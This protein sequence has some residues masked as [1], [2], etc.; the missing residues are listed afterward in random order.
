MTKEKDINIGSFKPKRKFISFINST[1]AGTNVRINREIAYIDGVKLSGM[2]EGSKFKITI[3]DEGTINFE[4]VDSNLTNTSMI[5]RLIGDIDNYDVK[6]Y[7]ERFVVEDLEFKDENGTKC[8]LEVE[9]QRPIDKLKSMSKT[10]P[11]SNGLDMLDK[12]FSTIKNNRNSNK[13]EDKVVEDKVVEDVV[14]EN[15]KPISKS[16]I[17]ETFN[18][19][20]D[21]KIKELKSRI[22]TIEKEKLKIESDIKVSESRIEQLSKELS[23]LET[24]LE[25]MSP[26]IEPNGYVFYV[27]HLKDSKVEIDESSKSMVDK[28]AVIMG[29]KKDVLV[30]HLSEGYYEIKVAD[31][32]K[33]DE[34]LTN[35]EVSNLIYKLDSKLVNNIDHFE[36][37]GDLNWHQII[38]KM[39]R[40]G[41]L[42][43]PEFDKISGSISYESEFGGGSPT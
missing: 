33:L 15:I 7:A 9:H 3:C 17:E 26:I 16:F 21:D 8:Y 14:L 34:S 24:R 40:L 27:S 23:T 25:T 11:T 19:M 18:K 32:N 2:L 36:Y 6:G 42:Q 39:I 29:L 13:E 10:S 20:N 38:D 35:E 4:E 12:F 5:S 28:I 1:R 30:K 31:I 37:R 43:S 41:F 22:E